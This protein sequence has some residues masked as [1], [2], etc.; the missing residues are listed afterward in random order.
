MP[1]V[2]AVIINA[3]TSRS[4]ITGQAGTPPDDALNDLTGTSVLKPICK[5]R[6]G[7]CHHSETRFGFT[8]LSRSLE[9]MPD[10]ACLGAPD[11]PGTVGMLAER[12]TTRH[13][14]HAT[15]A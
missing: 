4:G 3:P 11:E 14:E 13:R 6:P 5:L 8:G 10:R 7:C 9:P 12:P 15:D 1:A 2:C